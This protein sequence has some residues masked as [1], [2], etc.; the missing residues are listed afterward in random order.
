MMAGAVSLILRGPCE[1]RGG[2]VCDS[3]ISHLNV[4]P[5]ICEFIGIEKP[6]WLEG[7]SFLSILSGQNKEIN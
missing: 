1:F 2:V 7:E 6:S 3:L 5:T 4:F